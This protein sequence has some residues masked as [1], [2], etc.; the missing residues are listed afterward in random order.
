[1]TNEQPALWLEGL[2]AGARRKV[3]KLPGHVPGVAVSASTRLFDARARKYQ[4]R[5]IQCG[6]YKGHGTRVARPRV[7]TTAR[8]R[9]PY[10]RIDDA[11]VRSTGRAL[12]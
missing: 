11:Q 6:T 5:T 8:Q 3:R 4:N 2:G 10:E 7:L 12:Y 9:S 1:M